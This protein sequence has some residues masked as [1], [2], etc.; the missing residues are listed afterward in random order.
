[1]T[2]DI[3][4][5]EDQQGDNFDFT[6]ADP[7][8]PQKLA[9]LTVFD[10]SI[11]LRVQTFAGV[12]V[13]AKPLTSPSDGVARWVINEVDFDTMVAGDYLAKIVGIGFGTSLV[14]ETEPPMTVIV[15]PKFNP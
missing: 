15:H 9:D 11:T 5:T 13:L 2:A 12:E 8:D 1:M 10:T 14:R 6:I 4:V 7:D 3:E